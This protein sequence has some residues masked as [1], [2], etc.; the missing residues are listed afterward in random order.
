MFL[1]C[2]HYFFSLIFFKTYVGRLFSGTSFVCVA[3]FCAF[4]LLLFLLL[5]GLGHVSIRLC[6]L[7]ASVDNVYGVT[8][9]GY[10][11]L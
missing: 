11:C 1:L 3:A 5:L 8:G 10:G 7:C 6:V 4:L 9:Q 2:V